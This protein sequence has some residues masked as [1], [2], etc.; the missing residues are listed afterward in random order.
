MNNRAESGD[1][2]FVCVAGGSDDSG[3]W[4]ERF[5]KSEVGDLQGNSVCRGGSFLEKTLSGAVML[6][7]SS[8]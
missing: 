3:A 2:G 6:G 1:R 4:I 8:G 5:K 7:R